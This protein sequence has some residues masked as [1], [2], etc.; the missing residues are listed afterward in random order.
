MTRPLFTVPSLVLLPI[1][2]GCVG[3]AEP[4]AIRQR[5]Q[6]GALALW[7]G[8]GA[9]DSVGAHHGL[10]SENL[11]FV[12]GQSGQAFDLSRGHVRVPGAGFPVLAQSVTEQPASQP[13]A[14]A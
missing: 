3:P 2:L 6:S 5:L 4:D 8:E 9:A 13:G 11:A 1:L 14:P 12:S 7:K 10:S